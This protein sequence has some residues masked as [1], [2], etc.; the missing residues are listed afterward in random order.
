M[1]LCE[2]C[3][4]K[5]VTGSIKLRRKGTAERERHPPRSPIHLGHPE[6]VRLIKSHGRS[7]RVAQY[8]SYSSGGYVL[9]TVVVVEALV[10]VQEVVVVVVM[11]VLQEVVEVV[12][13]WR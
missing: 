10:L 2:R 13:G 9:V 4:N 7:E 8:S 1:Q 3:Q 12:V 5:F 11:V 6:S